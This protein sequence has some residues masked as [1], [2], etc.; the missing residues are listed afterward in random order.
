MEKG[1]SGDLGNTLTRVR[2]CVQGQH[3]LLSTC[4]VSAPSNS[5][6]LYFVVKV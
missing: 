6:E 4:A 1:S 2:L 5:K 3:Y